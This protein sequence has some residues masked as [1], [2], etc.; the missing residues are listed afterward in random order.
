ML[1]TYFIYLFICLFIYLFIHLIYYLNS[2]TRS[3]KYKQ[4]LSQCHDFVFSLNVNRDGTWL[5]S[6]ENKFH[7]LGAP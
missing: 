4:Q 6:V 2:I 3:Y 5:I 7:N 1:F